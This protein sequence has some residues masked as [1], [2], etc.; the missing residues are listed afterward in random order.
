MKRQEMYED[1]YQG[2]TFSFWMSKDV[3][4]LKR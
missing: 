4:N 2:A 1:V 3:L